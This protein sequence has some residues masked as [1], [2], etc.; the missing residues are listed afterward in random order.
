MTEYEYLIDS[1]IHTYNEFSSEW[2]QWRMDQ[3]SQPDPQGCNPEWRCNRESPIPEYM[4]N[5]RRPM[6]YNGEC[7][8]TIVP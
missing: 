1:A 6:S 4:Q 8:S 2:R 5:L 3:T 7:Q